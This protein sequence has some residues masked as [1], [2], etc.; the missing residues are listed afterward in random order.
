MIHIDR[1]MK[2]AGVQSKMILQVH[3]ELIF[4]VPESEID[5]MKKLIETGM[6]NAM[7]LKV[8]FLESE[9]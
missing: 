2:E 9:A 3:D 4:D 8:P 5:T 1:M 7:K 6:V